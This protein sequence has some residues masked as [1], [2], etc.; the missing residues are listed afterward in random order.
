MPISFLES[1]V[2]NANSQDGFQ[3]V[4]NEAFDSDESVIINASIDPTTYRDYV[5]V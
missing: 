4:L 5:V 1:R 3:S 2:L